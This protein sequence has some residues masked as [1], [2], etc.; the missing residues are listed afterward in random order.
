M[1]HHS[2]SPHNAGFTMIEIMVVL[3]ILGLMAGL[4]VPNM[5]G[6]TDSARISLAKQDMQNIVNA[7]EIYKLD[8]FAYPST[9]QGLNALVEKPRGKPEPK[10]W[11]ADGYLRSLPQDPWGNEYVYSAKRSREN[12]KPF[13]LESL[14]ADGKKGG[15]ELDADISVW[16]N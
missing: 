11:Q 7:L 15:K 2:R 12:N 16:D 13:Q 4:V 1:T 10:N 3:V 5:L 8:N 14:G 6:R 9:R